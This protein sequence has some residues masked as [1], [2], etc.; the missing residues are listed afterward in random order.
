MRILTP[1]CVVALVTSATLAHASNR[2][3]DM[4]TVDTAAHATGPRDPYTDGARTGKFDVYSEAR[5]SR[6]SA[7]RTP[8][9][10]T[11]KPCNG[12]ALQAGGRA[13]ARPIN[14]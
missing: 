13:E 14:G 10:R 5:R 7:I 9:A 8:M 12:V 3:V 4:A 11:A 1:L 2:A 6:I